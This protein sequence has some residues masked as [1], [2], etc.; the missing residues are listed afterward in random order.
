MKMT[1]EYAFARL[2]AIA[3]TATKIEAYYDATDSAA[4][5]IH[6]RGATEHERRRVETWLGCGRRSSGR[7]AWW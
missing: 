3:P 6:L 4:R 2:R 1:D 7:V 5:T